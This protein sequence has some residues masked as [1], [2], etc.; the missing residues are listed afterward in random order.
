MTT[1]SIRDFGAVGDG[2]T[3]DWQ[4]FL[5]ATNWLAE[6]PGRTLVFP[7]GVY[8]LDRFATHTFTLNLSDFR[9]IGEPGAVISV[10]GDYHQ[11]ALPDSNRPDKHAI[12]PFE[13]VGCSDF[14]VEGLTID[15][16]V[17]RTTRDDN[18]QSIGGHG[19]LTRNCHCYTLRNV[20]CRNLSGDGVYLGGGDQ[21]DTD[22]TLDGVTC[23]NN[24]RQGLTINLLRGGKIYD[25]TFRDSGRN[26][27]YGGS[28]PR[29]GV[30]IEPSK[31]LPER[32][33]NIAFRRC[34]L[35]DN[36]GSQFVCE[37]PERVEW[38]TLS[39]CSIRA[40][41][42]SSKLAVVMGYR[43]AR[44]VYS[45]IDTGRGA[46]YPNYTPK[47]PSAEV[48]TLIACCHIRTCGNGIQ[49]NGRGPLEIRDN[50]II[51][52]H[53]EPA[54]QYIP[55][56]SHR[57]AVFS[58]NTVYIPREMHTGE[59]PVQLASMVQ[60]ASEAKGNRWLDNLP[61]DQ[62]YSQSYKGITYPFPLS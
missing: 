56:L 50:E 8:H 14:T 35:L 44:L 55:N 2:R 30:D 43:E 23:H 16:N 10:K 9:I 19:I 48:N 20:V 26:G 58:G 53:R 33:G 32:T 27:E 34:R 46:I 21:H 59:K 22:A 28:S 24:T 57:G 5:Y 29:A 3:D 60:F 6:R 15:G 39:D 36:L 37:A 1:L 13:F 49:S 52:Y 40:A 7:R 17:D 54:R 12:I 31:D 45:E 11:T 61:D 41:K 18:V 25:C 47:H 42:D 62:R 51:G 4:A 38:V